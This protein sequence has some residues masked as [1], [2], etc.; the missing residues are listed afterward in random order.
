MKSPVSF[1]AYSNITPIGRN[2]EMAD[3]CNPSGS[4]FGF[5]SY[6]VAEAMDGSRVQ[7]LVSISAVDEASDTGKATKMAN[8][9]VTR[10]ASGRLPVGFAEWEYARP[11]Y[12]SDAY[13]PEEEIFL[14]SREAE[15]ENFG[16]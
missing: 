13:D 6:V 15:E 5:A 11:S 2:P 3:V 8:A 9:L 1:Y 7:K 14:E 10:L 12:G 16:F 4:I